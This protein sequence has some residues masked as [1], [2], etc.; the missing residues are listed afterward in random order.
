MIVPEDSDRDFTASAFVVNDDSQVLLIKH[1]ELGTWLQ[2]GGHVED[3]E[4]PDET[5]LRKVLQETG[6]RVEQVDQP[7]FE[8]DNSENL[9]T[10]FHM[11]LH[12]IS[13]DHVH[14]DFCYLARPVEE[15]HPDRQEHDDQ[16]W[17]SKE[18]VEE[19]EDIPENVKKTALRA[20]GRLEK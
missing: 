3:D 9:P 14:C 1:S 20:I 4:T 16:K 18:E 7:D 6:Y 8:V 11:N 2:P 17:F 13:E 12:P 5:A 15:K 10:P 19:L